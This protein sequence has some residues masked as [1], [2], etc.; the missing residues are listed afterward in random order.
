MALKNIDSKLELEIRR[1]FSHRLENYKILRKWI[2]DAIGQIVYHDQNLYRHNTR[3]KDVLSVLTK[4]D[5]KIQSEKTLVASGDLSAADAKWTNARSFEDFEGL[6]DDWVGC[7]VISYTQD[8]IPS[9]HKQITQHKRFKIQRVTVHDSYHHQ[10][11]QNL[12]LR[13]GDEQKLNFNGYVGIHYVIE[14]IP[15]DPC[16]QLQPHIFHKFELQIRTLLQE[17]WG[18]VQHEVIYKGRLPELL[19]VERSDA[20]ASLAGFLSQCDAELSRL[21]KDP[22][23]KALAESLG[24]DPGVPPQ[25]SRPTPLKRTPS[26]RRRQG[27][28]RLNVPKNG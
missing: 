9:L 13:K 24:Q 27:H 23:V 14:P 12:R 28:L 6:V 7:R 15:V 25:Y 16:F 2:E 21:S 3:I 17:T 10:T 4:I 1:N 5:G 8:T 26:E 19:K 18:Q 22:K 11:F 20:F